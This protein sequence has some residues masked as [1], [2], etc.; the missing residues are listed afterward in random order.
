M[1]KEWTC[2][3]KDVTFLG[4]DPEGNEYWQIKEEVYKHQNGGTI[5][6]SSIAAWPL[7]CQIVT[8]TI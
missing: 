2:D 5:W 3:P 7:Y 4:Y 6:L 1:P 8:I